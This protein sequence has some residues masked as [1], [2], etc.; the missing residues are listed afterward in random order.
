MNGYIQI[1]VGEKPIGL[2]FAWLAVK[3][4][5]QASEGKTDVYFAETEIDGKKQQTFTS[6]GIAKL[7]QCA[8]RNNNEIKE[9]KDELTFEDFYNWVEQKI[10]TPEGLTEIG[11]VIE[12]YADSSFSKKLVAEIEKKSMNGQPEVMQNQ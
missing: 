1:T 2:K 4:F 10:E 5:T 9:V 6:L 12:V 8:Y 3:W 7:I 11:K